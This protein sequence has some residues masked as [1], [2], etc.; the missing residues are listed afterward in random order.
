MG[1]NEIWRPVVGYEGLYEVSNLGRV[2]SLE[3]QVCRRKMG[4]KLIKEHYLSI[5]STKLGYQRAKLSRAGEGGKIYFVHRLVAMA[6]IPNPENK[7]FIDHINGT[8]WDNN[9]FNLRWCTPKENSNFEIARRRSSESKMGSK[10]PFFWEM[11]Y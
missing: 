2:K 1:Q 3:R 8:P 11:W 5:M 7:P 6:F 4:V 10:N 9:V